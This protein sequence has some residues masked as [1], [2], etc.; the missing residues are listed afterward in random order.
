LRTKRSPKQRP[1]DESGEAEGIDTIYMLGPVGVRG[2]PTLEE[3]NDLR[4][5]DYHELTG[6][7]IPPNLIEAARS[8]RPHASVIWLNKKGEPVGPNEKAA[9]VAV[10]P[11]EKASPE[12]VHR[13]LDDAR[14]KFR[15]MSEPSLPQT[16]GEALAECLRVELSR[17]KQANSGGARANKLLPPMTIGRIAI[18]M[19]DTHVLYGQ[20]PGYALA[21][22]L[23]EL[24]DA[25]KKKLTSSRAFV[26]RY[27]A[28]WVLAQKPDVKT[29]ELARLVAA[30][31]SSIMRWRQDPKFHAM[32]EDNKE[33]IRDFARRGLWPPRKRSD[34]ISP[35]A[36]ESNVDKPE[37]GTRRSSR[38]SERK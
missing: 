27:K 1:G 21:D 23:R 25:D 38:G 35:I 28:A 19:L 14:R 31:P 32:V 3:W 11:P 30:E 22:L 2:Q 13:F 36:K 6:Y 18:D 7:S 5:S 26:A 12:E 33:T 34:Q 37:E 8:Y 15:E 4:E 16:A 9:R 24:I 17:Y 20:V 29:R 10:T